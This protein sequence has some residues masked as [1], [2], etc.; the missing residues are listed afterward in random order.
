MNKTQLYIKLNDTWTELDLSDN[1]PFPIIFN[2]ADVRDISKK[3]SS[4]SKTLTLPHTDNNSN[5]LNFIFDVANESSFNANKKVRAYVLNDTIQVF[6]GFFQLVKIKTNDNNKFNYEC[7]IFGESDTLIKNI[8]EGFLTEL[9]FSELNHDYNAANIEA[10]WTRDW[11]SGYYYPLMDYNN[12]WTSQ[13]LK[14]YGSGN[15]GPGP[16]VFDFKPAVYVKYIWD[17]IF[18]DAGFTYDSTFLNSDTFSNLIIPFA[19]T[20]LKRD[21]QFDFF[22]TFRVNLTNNQGIYVTGSNPVVQN[23]F[24]DIR[25]ATEFGIRSANQT[26]SR[27]KF[28]DDVN[29]PFG[30]PSNL[31]STTLYEYTNDNFPPTGK[32]QRFV[33]DLDITLRNWAYGND[34]TIAGINFADFFWAGIRVKRSTNPYTYAAEPEGFCVP[35]EN[36]TPDSYFGTAPSTNRTKFTYRLQGGSINQTNGPLNS[37]TDGN[38][39]VSQSPGTNGFRRYKGRLATL[40]LDGSTSERLP[41]FNGEKLWVEVFYSFWTGN[42]NSTTNQ[43]KTLQT[44]FNQPPLLI[45]SGSQIFNTI[46]PDFGPGQPIDMSQIMPEKIKKKDFITSI[47]KMFNLF[48][49][50][51]RDNVNNLIIEPR[52]IYYTKGKVRDWSVKLDISKAI[53]QDII[54]EAQNKKLLFTYKEDKDKMNVDYKTDW[55]QIYGQYQYEIDNDFITGEKKIDVIFSPTPMVDVGWQSSQ[56]TNFVIPVIVPNDASTDIKNYGGIKILLRGTQSVS[57]NGDYWMFEGSPK[58]Y[59][60]YAGHFNHPFDPTED[61]NWGQTE[62]LFYSQGRAVNNNLFNNYYR[63]MIEELTDKDSRI[64]TAYFYLTPQDLYDLRF[65]DSIFVQSLASSTGNYFRINKIEYD[66]MRPGSYKVELLKAN[67]IKIDIKRTRKATTTKPIGTRPMKPVID[68]DRATFG[69][70]NT[71]NGSGVI[72]GIVNYIPAGIKADVF[73]NNNTIQGNPTFATASAPTT[74]NNVGIFVGD[75]NTIQA[76]SKS[77]VIIASDFSTIGLNVNRVAIIG[78]V[79]N[80][81]A[82][83]VENSVIIGGNGE[84]VRQSNMVKMGGVLMSATNYVGAGRGE[85]LNRFPDDKVINFISAGRGVVRELG[86]NSKEN[87]VSAGYG[88][89]I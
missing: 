64:I 61:I 23:A 37:F 48:I 13:K 40:L 86:T 24:G 65:Y 75:N 29:P 62:A 49:E 89:I 79:N 85:V 15:L 63:K 33:I 22:N 27:V 7:V 28:D 58:Y 71:N 42:N 56:I 34:Y 88:F 3:N 5:I 14:L 60:P 4:Y 35:L 26:F 41:L 2:I 30:D 19:G 8:G 67:D 72:S 36:I 51:S 6:E 17:K 70:N 77:S 32:K 78:G 16:K 20:S 46:E 87:I 43:L 38:N 59:Y 68:R 12:R 44:T 55:N 18:Q 69:I 80:K 83:N 54:A 74:F 57:L 73:G 84:V 82:N 31:W 1:T 50:P 47:V 39:F 52:D 25:F 53:D 45:N 11:S 76:D 81:I 21:P 10:S 66:P 9:N